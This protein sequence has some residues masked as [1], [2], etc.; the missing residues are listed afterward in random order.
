MT[1]EYTNEFIKN[2]LMGGIVIG[3]YS[4]IIKFISPKLAGHASGSMPLVFTYVI[5]K[6]YQDFGYNK[7]KEVAKIGLTGGFF[8]LSYAIIVNYMFNN[9]YDL[10]RTLTVAILAFIFLNYTYYNKYYK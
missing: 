3:I 6:T 1:N 7:T 5:L 4:I 9:N 2:F 10:L 8:W